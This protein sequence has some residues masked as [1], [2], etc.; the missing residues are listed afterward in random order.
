[1]SRAVI[2]IVLAFMLSVGCLSTRQWGVVKSHMYETAVATGFGV[3]AGVV[4]GL[5]G[6]A[7]A[8]GGM[9]AGAF[10]G[11]VSKP[12]DQVVVVDAQPKPDD[13]GLKISGDNNNNFVF[14]ASSQE[15]SGGIPWVKYGAILAI[16]LVLAV[17][18]WR[19][20]ALAA[21]KEAFGA[22]KKIAA[23]GAEAIGAKHSRPKP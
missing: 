4:G 11:E 6:V 8:A 22:T 12:D 5:P 9:I 18:R 2:S 3:L 23:R 15:E 21:A 10:A 13:G 16:M 20:L 19:E 7:I 17:P 1:M 14:S